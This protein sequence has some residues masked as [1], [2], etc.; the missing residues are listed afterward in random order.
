MIG[1]GGVTRRHIIRLTDRLQLSTLNTKTFASG[2]FGCPNM[3]ITAC[4]FL[5]EGIQP[6]VDVVNRVY[7]VLF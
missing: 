5:G 7:S 2:G 1:N 4:V 3:A 6:F